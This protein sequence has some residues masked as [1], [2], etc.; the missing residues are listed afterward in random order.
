MLIATY[1]V[2]ESQHH[3]PD[4]TKRL[5]VKL[6]QHVGPICANNVMSNETLGHW[7]DLSQMM[8]RK[9]RDSEHYGAA[10][11]HLREAKRSST[12]ALLTRM[13]TMTLAW[14]HGRRVSQTAKKDSR[15]ST[16][17]A[18]E[19]M[20]IVIEEL[21]TWKRWTTRTLCLRF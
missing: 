11:E 10:L 17:G 1:P 15:S 4:D 3:T 14:S 9:R 18:S 20:S 5:P 21:R 13:M 7:K 8:T 16:G 19:S 2:T 12:E 6:S